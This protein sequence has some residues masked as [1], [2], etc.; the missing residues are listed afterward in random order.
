MEITFSHSI[1]IGDVVQTL[2]IGIALVTFYFQNRAQ[3]KAQRH[4]VYQNLEI[5]SNEIF[6]FEASHRDEIL[7]FKSRIA[8]ASFV[9]EQARGDMDGK[10]AEKYMLARKYYE[11]T[12]NIFEVAARLRRADIVPHEVF[13]SWVAW[14]FDT[15]CEWGFRAAWGDLRDNYTSEMRSV[16]DDFVTRLIKQWDIP[17]ARAANGGEAL[18]PSD[19]DVEALRRDFYRHVGTY[20]HCKAILNWLD[21]CGPVRLPAHPL[22]YQ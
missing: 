9:A 2:G 11:N 12:C 4:D 18:L 14:Y 19:S 5:E 21:D 3:L 20:F 10:A 15:L 1:S 8:A 6:K 13:G 7:G 22:A 16:F 17:A